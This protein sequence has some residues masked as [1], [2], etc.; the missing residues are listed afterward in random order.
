MSIS[1]NSSTCQIQYNWIWLDAQKVF[2]TI[3][4]SNMLMELKFICFYIFAL[5]HYIVHLHSIW[6]RMPEFPIAT[7]FCSGHSTDDIEVTRIKLCKGPDHIRKDIE[8][9]IIYELGTVQ[10]GGLN[11]SFTA[12]KSVFI[13]PVLCVILV[14][15]NRTLSHFCH[16]LQRPCL[17][18]SCFVHFLSSP[19]ELYFITAVF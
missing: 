16:F 13:S 6:L 14:F 1:D 5:L 4:F 11:V 7:H 17:C 19:T 18:T 15:T 9:R 8:Q 2:L 10:P 3:F 12:S